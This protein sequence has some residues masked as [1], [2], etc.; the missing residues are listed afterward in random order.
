M[1]R[2]DGNS[3]A[4]RYAYFD[5]LEPVLPRNLEVYHR[6]QHQFVHIFIVLSG[7]FLYEC[8]FLCITYKIDNVLIQSCHVHLQL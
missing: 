2:E 4:V 1:G 5:I 6:Q 8:G 7:V 3:K